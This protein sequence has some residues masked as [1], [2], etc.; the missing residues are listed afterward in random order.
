M[1]HKSFTILLMLA[2]MMFAVISLGGCGGSSSSSNGGGTEDSNLTMSDTWQDDEAAQE[3]VN[4]LTSG[5]VI[6]LI[7]LRMETIEKKS[8]GSVT[9]KYYDMADSIYND[10]DNPEVPY[11]AAEV[12]ARYNSEDVIVL[13]NADLEL[14]NTVRSDLGL[15]EEDADTFGQSGILEAYGLACI[16]TDGLRN[17]FTYV[18]PRMGDIVASADILE[19]NNP[20]IETDSLESEDISEETKSEVA[21]KE[22]TMRDFQI[23]RWVNFIRW[24]GNVSVEALINTAFAAS[25]QVKAADDDFAK[26]CDAQT[27][28]FDFSYANVHTNGPTFNNVHYSC[29]EFNRT[30]NNFVSVKIFTAHSF[31]SGKDF[32]IVESTNTTVP[33]NFVDT[34]IEYNG[35]YRNYLYGFTRNFGAEFHIDGGNMSTNDV[36]LIHN[37]PAN[38]NITKTYS[39]GMS[40]SVNG[41]LGVNKDGASAEVGGGVTY[42]N[43][44]TWTVSEYNIVNSSMRDYSA[45]AKWYADVNGPGGGGHHIEKAAHTWEGV[46]ATTASKNQL[47]YDSYFMWEVGRDYW[48]NHPNMKM[49]LTFTVGDGICLG[50]CRQWFK[51]YSRFD[52]TYTTTKRDSLKLDQPPHTTVSKRTFAFTSKAANSQAFTLLAEDNWTIK[53]IPSWLHFTSTSGNATGSSEK[54]I[55]FDVDEN[56]GTSPRKAVVTI[57]SD[58]D[59]IK[60]EIG[61][62]GK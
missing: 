43:S 12:L 26:I 35:Y 40:W 28:T 11:N 16:K 62:S 5:D 18:V 47:Q 6:K 54:Q 61:Q 9:M 17:L 44:K 33:M 24:M 59:T 32:Y 56:T 23:D 46:N 51:E 8:D 58:R 25:Y 45:S 36:A 55:L 4:R 52:S 14:V 29:T 34:K 60:L 48:K 7:F 37:A 13:M 22:Y 19:G 21:P 42:S 30:R 20:E 31:N 50:K 3:V 39:E 15:S 2:A 49:N 1:K 41:K 38:A 10:A 27:K 53:D 57:T